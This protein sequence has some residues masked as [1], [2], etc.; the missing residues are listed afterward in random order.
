MTLSEDNPFEWPEAIGGDPARVRASIQSIRLTSGEVIET[1]APGTTVIV[2]A[3]NAGKSTLLRQLNTQL[4]QGPAQLDATPPRL[5]DKAQLIREFATNDLIHWLAGNTSLIERTQMYGGD[6]FAAE[7]MSLDANNVRRGAHSSSQDHLTDLYHPMVLHADAGSR[8]GYGFTASQRGEIGEQPSAP[9][10]RFQDNRAL[11]GELSEL[12]RRIFGHPL[13]LDDFAGSA[14]RIRVGQVD[15]PAPARDEAL[16]DFGRAVSR[17]PLLD[18]QGDGMRSFFGVMIP[19]LAGA[20]KIIL[21]DEPEAFLHP[22]QARALGKELAAAAHRR[23]AQ[24]IVATHDKDFISGVLDAEG[25][26]S[27]VRLVRNQSSTIPTQ[28]PL[29]RLRDLRDDRLLRYSNIL[30]GLFC[31]LVVLCESEQDCR[32]YEA[33]L[34]H[35]VS[36]FSDSSDVYTLPASDVLFIP[37]NGKGGFANFVPALR[38]LNVPT[39]IVPDI[40][41][42]KSKEQTRTA[43]ETLSG[44]WSDVDRDFTIATSGRRHRASPKTV[45]SVLAA[46]LAV[47]RPIAESDPEQRYEGDVKRAVDAAIGNAQDPWADAKHFGVRAFSGDERNALDRMMSRFDESGL[48]LVHVGELE[49]FAPAFTKGKTWLPQAVAAGAYTQPEAQLLITRVLKFH[50][51]VTSDGTS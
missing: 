24:V 40:D 37:V 49:G 33:A 26:L 36:Q 32:F 47:L 28:P 10:H 15:I 3:N 17:L 39:V 34:D 12:S 46:T 45:K 14:V 6:Y 43:L 44:Q 27:I 23:G 4:Q 38:D 29:Q 30:N 5:V 41:L 51:R 1:A 21:V 19:L 16:G 7:N 35:Y 31:Q 11:F 48:V 8:L 9:L 20:Q 50:E 18:N 13:L 42:L 2:G 25:D 22:P